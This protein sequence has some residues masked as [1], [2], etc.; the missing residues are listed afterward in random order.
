[1][2]YKPEEYL[3]IA[4]IQ[5]FAFC[6]RQWALAYL[7]Q[8]WDE[9]VLTIEGHLLHEKAHDETIREKRGKK[10]IVRGMPVSSSR[11]GICGICDVVEFVQDEDG[12]YLPAYDTCYRVVPIEYKRGRPKEGE[13][14]ILQLVLQTM[15]LEDML[16]TQ[17]QEGYFY[18]G[19]IRRREK[20]SMSA[21]YRKHV[22]TMLKQMR[23]YEAKK[24]T[25]LVKVRK[26]CKS[27]SIKNRCLPTLNKKRSAIAYIKRKLSE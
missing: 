4:E 12:I 8:Q 10:I 1:M 27:C 26:R 3:Q 15:C 14:D 22:I 25:P 5:H 6:P 7:E 16:A 13:E 24:Y 11:L 20:V 2:S 17:I 23:E 18:Y 19:E 9:N 21:E